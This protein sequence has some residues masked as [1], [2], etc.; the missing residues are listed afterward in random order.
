[1]LF[2][3]SWVAGCRW[4]VELFVLVVGLLGSEEAGALPGLDR[5]GADVELG[6]DR[7]EGERAAGAEPVGV[8]CEVVVAAEWRTILALK[9]WGAFIRI[10]LVSRGICRS[11]LRHSYP[12]RNEAGRAE[13]CR[14]T[15]SL[16]SPGETA[17]IG[18]PVGPGQTMSS[19]TVPGRPPSDL[20]NFMNGSDGTR[21][22]TSGVKVRRNDSRELPVPCRAEE[23]VR[24]EAERQRSRASGVRGCAAFGAQTSSTPGPVIWTS[25]VPRCERK[26]FVRS[27]DRRCGPNGSRSMASSDARTSSPAAGRGLG[28]RAG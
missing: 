17:A 3:E 19:M 18:R 27:G 7:V 9:V 6:G 25:P 8:A 28:H 1:L 23:H 14:A 10:P 11:S 12:S 26:R 22:S 5:A 20:G 16:R 4:V 21:P 2:V 15:E 24:P 13:Q